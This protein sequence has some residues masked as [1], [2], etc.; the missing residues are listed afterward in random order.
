MADDFNP[1]KHHSRITAFNRLFFGLV[2][3]FGVLLGL[4]LLFALNDS[5]ENFDQWYLGIGLLVGFLAI[6][7]LKNLSKTM[8]KNEL[9]IDPNNIHL[10]NIE[11]FF[12]EEIEEEKKK[13]QQKTI[14]PPPANHKNS[15][16]YNRR[17]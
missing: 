8:A 1:G 15:L 7:V 3:V 14:N 5:A 16:F 11:H 10:P 13:N 4:L 17:V 2:I 12:D 6:P 9:N